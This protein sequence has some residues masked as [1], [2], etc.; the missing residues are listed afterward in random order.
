VPVSKRVTSPDDPLLDELCAQL[1]AGSDELDATGRWP[2]AQLEACG[3]Y[4]VFEWF[5]PRSAGGQE[6]SD[7]DCVRGYLRLSAACLTTAFIIT[8][9]TGACTRIVDGV[10]E[11]L[12]ERWLPPLVR[13]DSFATVGISHLTTSR[14][15][16]GKPALQA[17]IDGNGFVLDGFSP[18]VTGA[19]HAEHVVTGAELDDGKQTLVLLPTNLQG[20]SVDEPTR[21]MA[22]SASHTGAVRCEH[23]RLSRE[24]LLAGPIENVMAHGAGA[25]TGGLQTS[26]LAVGLANSAISYLESEARKRADLAEPTAALRAEQ[27]RVERLVLSLAADVPACSKEDLRLAANQLALRSTQAALTAAKGSGYVAGHPA[28]RW[29]REALFFLVW[30]CPQPVAAAALCELAGLSD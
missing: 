12:R 21:L 24:W 22:L 15:H 25:G 23:V 13:G 20:V 10:N 8:Q 11:V 5:V 19:K 30:S 27:Q 29:C 26:T 14:R 2:A 9:R 18:W 17:Q 3:R 16:L 28:G 4:G 1:A 7:A 6:W